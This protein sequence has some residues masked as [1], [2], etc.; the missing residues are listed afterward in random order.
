MDDQQEIPEHHRIQDLEGWLQHNGLRG[1]DDVLPHAGEANRAEEE[2]RFEQYRNYANSV[3]RNAFHDEI[4]AEEMREKERE[5]MLDALKGKTIRL[6]SAVDGGITDDLPAHVLA[7][8]CETIFSMANSWDQF[9]NNQ[10]MEMSLDHDISSIQAFADVIVHNKKAAA[11][12]TEHLI[13]CCFLA[14]YLCAD[15][16]LNEIVE[17]MVNS[18]DNSNCLAFCQIADKFQLHVLFERSLA[19]MM[20]RLGDMEEN[21]AFEDLT[22]EL[23]DRIGAIKAAI[24]SSINSKSRLYFGSLDEYIASKYFVAWCDY[25]VKSTSDSV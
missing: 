6:Q 24:E 12:P 14:H 23:R 10:P 15:K 8:S 3:Y 4:L 9:S 13:D 5:R 20:D 19:H 22:P 18:I 11:I 7:A 1:Q 16:L 2:A 17:I 25:T 21:E